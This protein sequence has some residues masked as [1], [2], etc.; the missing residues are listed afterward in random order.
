MQKPADNRVQF[1]LDFDQDKWPNQEQ[2]PLN[3]KGENRSV[4][5]IV[6]KDIEESTN[7]II[8]TGFT[9]LSTLIDLFGNKDFERHQKVRILIGFE[10]NLR[11][12]KSYIKYD[13][14]REIKDYWLKAG[15]SIMQGGAIIHLIEKIN[16]GLIEF[17][18][19]DKLHAKIYVG[20]NYAVLG[21]SNFSRTGLNLQDE[22]NIRVNNNPDDR[23]EQA[24]YASIKQIADSYWNDAESYNDKIIE[25]LKALIKE[26][27]WQEALARAVAE[28]L[29]GKWLDDYKE[30][31]GKLE[32]TT[33][34]PTQL[35]GLA[36]GVSIL[37]NQSNV[38]IADPTGA[39]KTK[40]CTSLVLSLQH[41][42][43]EIGKNYSTESLII[44]PPLVVEKWQNEFKSFK[45]LGHLH[46]SMGLLS[47]TSGKN[48]KAIMGELDIANIL[49]IDEAHNYLS[50]NSNRTNLIKDNKADY[51]ILITATPISKKAEDLLRLIELLDVDNL[52]DDDFASFQELNLKPHLR[53]HKEENIEN[54]RRFISKFTVRRTKKSLNKQIDKEPEHYRNRLGETC[55]FPEQHEH[56]YKT[57]ETKNDI[58][59]VSEINQLASKL[60]GITYLP[61]FKLPKYEINKEESLESYVNRRIVSARALSIYMIRAALRSSHVALVEHIE[62]TK[63]AMKHFSFDGKSKTSGNKLKKIEEFIEAGKI[64]PKSKKFKE[65]FF[66]IWLTDITEYNKACQED[67]NIY[68][69]ISQLA[70][71]LS[72]QRELGK[73]KSLVS[74]CEK[75]DNI[76]AFD[77]TVITL[78]YLRK[79]FENHYPLQKLL[80][81]SGSENDKDSSKVLEIF[82]L[83]S[84][85]KE[86]YIALC[87]DKMSESVDLQKASCVFLL[88]I[89][90]VLRIVE[91]RIGRV[92]RMDSM[93]KEIEIFWPDDS[94]EYSLKADSR[95][96]ET[97]NM[98][99]QIYGSNFEIPDRLKGKVFSNL[100]STEDLINE[101]KEFVDKDESWTGIHDSFQCIVDLK[102]GKNALIN[103][104]TFQEFVN[105]TSEVKTRVSFLSSPKNWCFIALRGDKKKSPRWYFIDNDKNIHTDYPD[106]CEQIRKN[107]NNDA[108]QLSWNEV[109][110]E[111]YVIEFKRK[112]IEL[113]NPKKRRALNV[114][115]HILEKKINSRE[116]NGEVKATYKSMLKILQVK[117]TLVIDYERLAEDW[118]DLL[119]PYL[120]SKR[121]KNRRKKVVLNLYSLKSEY[122]SIILE[123]EILEKM[124][125]TSIIADAIDK[126]IAA[127]II[128]V[129]DVNQMEVIL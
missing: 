58:K 98:V 13:L 25:L 38:L 73:V 44:C 105:V 48:R 5:K 83:D 7:Y 39:G 102:E 54:L 120:K 19:K 47:N 22:A 70:K 34:W 21:S 32:S 126:R 33:L 86:K 129:G 17:K 106:V 18:F 96:V 3:I 66:P 71:Q 35:K 8:L 41:W 65:Q 97:N 90:S 89:P 15:L 101:Y 99:E 10:P 57:K 46:R 42:L 75:H 72:G 24:Q 113:L 26:V 108:T 68:K 49:T 45:K 104:R 12:R 111:R 61:N 127:C 51:K 109:I 9:S 62:G 110:L 67:L 95:L 82:K 77:S 119:K 60:K 87:S 69:K 28:I 128:G 55:R 114:A 11:G 43:Y 37:Q 1:T 6:Y 74:A 121:E 20:D 23:F 78:Y 79:L 27:T 59:I 50:P 122:K 56:T 116:L 123:K 36:Q 103:E 125:D 40:L 29:E 91:Q 115:Q 93:H 107:I 84:T 124:I 64:P 14:A 81:A 63:A 53:S 76:L 100:D 80:I 30:I 85:E 112:E 52:T 88:D 16:A 117:T 2:F 118:I 4:E 94:E 31:L 92:D